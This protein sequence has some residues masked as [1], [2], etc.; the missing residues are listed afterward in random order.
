[1]GTRRKETLIDIYEKRLIDDLETV[2]A[3]CYSDINNLHNYPEELASQIL[4][5]LIEWACQP[6]NVTP[7]LLA[8]K[9]LD[10]INKDWLKHYFLD[11]AK[12][13]IDFSDYW[14]YRRLVEL[15]V[16]VLPE[17]KQE[18]LQLGAQSENEEV[19]EVVE[20]FKDL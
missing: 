14:E 16:F 6:Q 17:L 18:I 1:M 2:Q 3:G 10:E 12:A 20:D 11:V 9:K 15:V 4:R 7:I 5:K 8:R 13:C 19:R